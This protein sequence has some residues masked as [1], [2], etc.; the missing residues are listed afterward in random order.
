MELA[1]MTWTMALGLFMVG[2]ALAGWLQ[3]YMVAEGA[4]GVVAGGSRGSAGGASSGNGQESFFQK[5]KRCCRECCER[6]R[7]CC[8]KCCPCSS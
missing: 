2:G 6:C 3:T 1:I 7:A 4:G 8:R 5:I